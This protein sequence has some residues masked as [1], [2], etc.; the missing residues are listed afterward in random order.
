MYTI[1][2]MVVLRAQ[3]ALRGVVAPCVDNKVPQLKQLSLS[4]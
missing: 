3:T 2:S 1:S 4:F